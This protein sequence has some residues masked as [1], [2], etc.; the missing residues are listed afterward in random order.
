MKN[1]IIENKLSSKERKALPEKYFG[2]PDE[3]K[4]P[5]NDEDHIRK[6]IQF[7]RYCESSKKVVLANNINKRAKNL[8]LQ[9][10]LSK[11]NP[12][13]KYADKNIVTESITIM[14]GNS[15]LINFYEL[16]EDLKMINDP[17]SIFNSFG[18]EFSDIFRDIIQRC[19]TSIHEQSNYLEQDIINNIIPKIFASKAV[20][21]TSNLITIINKIMYDYYHVFFEFNNYQYTTDQ[22][23]TNTLFISIIKDIE[24]YLTYA[25]DNRSLS[26]DNELDI[27]K[28]LIDNMYCNLYIIK[29]LLLEFQLN[30]FIANARFSLNSTDEQITHI[31]KVALNDKLTKIENLLDYIDHKEDWSLYIPAISESLD[32]IEHS[33]SI[34]N[35]N[36]L[37]T[38]KYLEVIKNETKNQV[39]IILMSGVNVGSNIAKMSGDDFSL[40]IKDL[41]EEIKFRSIINELS[42]LCNSKNIKFYS[43]NYSLYIDSNDLVFISKLDKFV[44]TII[45]ITDKYGETIYLGFN[46][47][48]A[49]LLGKNE[50]V[51]HRIILI[52]IYEYGTDHTDDFLIDKPKSNLSIIHID[53]VKNQQVEDTPL[54]E[55][56]SIDKSGNIKFEIKPKKSYM[57]EYS[58]THKILIANYKAKNY[59]AMKDNLAYL[60]ALITTIER[61][62]IYNKSSKVSSD[63]KEDAGKARTFA[64][65]D[66]KTYMREVQKND[67]SFNF[68]QY[69]EEKGYDK[70]TIN[71]TRDSIEGVKRIFQTIMLS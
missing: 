69:Y 42:Y 10:K 5:L 40:Y 61:N 57:D 65:N 66:F 29:R 18:K 63:V 53:P 47:K 64:I 32:F 39:D 12:F 41:K 35:L 46:D 55:G 8:Q 54:L 26:I 19:Y 15:G 17:S 14:D 52:A 11:D 34:S 37:N 33:A 48:D 70:L 62:I 56:I 68:T 28:S 1:I 44:R 27:L 31:N 2:L 51:E 58:D 7:F 13:Y 21:G 38:S 9:F 30:C 45:P 24:L 36:F 60:F 71:I 20:S 50:E 49:Y 59:D 16:S 4:Y 43:K 22:Y 6:A 23:K 67:P 3:Q 25:I